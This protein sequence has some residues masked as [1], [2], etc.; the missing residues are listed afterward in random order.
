MQTTNTFPSGASPLPQRGGTADF[1]SQLRQ[2]RMRQQRILRRRMFQ[3]WWP[4]ILFIILGGLVAAVLGQFTLGFPKIVLGILATV[5]IVFLAV[6][7]VEFGFFL[8]ALTGTAFFPELFA[9]K[10][11]EIYPVMLLLVF[12]FFILLV[13]VAF[14]LQSVV[15]PSFWAIWPQMGLITVA[16]V[17]NIL[18]QLSWTPGVPHRLNSNPI[19][20]DEIL[21]IILCCVPLVIIITTTGFLTK[22]ERLIEYIQRMILI[23][24]LIGSIIVLIE[25][26]RIGASIYTFRYS[27]PMVLW[28]RLRALVQLLVLGTIIAYARLLYATSW[29]KRIMYAAVTGINLLA[30]YLSLENSWWLEV[31]V[32]LIVMTIFYSRRLFF[33][34]CAAGLLML[35]L[36][37][38]ELTKLQAVKSADS[39][40]FTIWKD[41]LRIWK[42]H[43][44][45]GVGPGNLWTYDQYFTKLPRFLRDFNKTGLGVAHN[46]YIQMLGEMGIVGL[47]FYLSFIVIIAYITIQLYQRSK[48]PQKRDDR[49]L[50]LVGLGLIFGSAAA[51][52]F[53][54]S[55]FLP[56]RQIGIFHELTNII[57]TWIIFGFIIYK[58]Q[59]WRKAQRGV[60]VKI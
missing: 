51:D 47:F 8:V 54:G 41:M 40:R 22:K 52:F 4:R 11:L 33:I 43:P 7:F 2:Q 1:D 3:L 23:S 26:K 56:P 46:G 57:L 21:G 60:N 9:I 30:V 53:A 59:L 55:F 27:E 58:D 24:A 42:M 49:K 18:I 35:P 31:G 50:G 36:M 32:A 37:K 10:S 25:F 20:Y 12:M 39:Y 16:I 29:G 13:R 6:R 15:W 45:L 34:L 38:N 5:V 28:M 48:S 14:R 44:I 19:I 17:S